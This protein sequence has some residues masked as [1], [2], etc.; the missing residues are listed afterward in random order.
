VVVAGDTDSIMVSLPEGS[1][2][3]FLMEKFH[4]ALDLHLKEQCNIDKVTTRFKYEK[5]FDRFICIKKKNYVGRM[6]DDGGTPV[7]KLYAKGLELIKKDTITYTRNNLKVL[8]HHLLNED[9]DLN[10]YDTLIKKYWDEMHT[11]TFV[12]EEICIT[13]KISK[14]FEEYK[15]TPVHVKLGKKLWARGNKE[16]IVDDTNKEDKAVWI[17]DYAGIF[18]RAFYWE[19]YVWPPMRRILEVIYPKH[20]WDKFDKS[21]IPNPNKKKRKTRTKKVVE[22]EVTVDEE[23][24]DE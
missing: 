2:H 6:V 4:E 3:L 15:S 14:P 17:E 24:K 16:L 13:R 21:K 18:D 9:R 11:R 12:K 22:P 7:D 20:E 10:F 1:D 23:E 8:L 19:K 5:R